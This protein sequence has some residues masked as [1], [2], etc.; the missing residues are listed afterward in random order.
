MNGEE[1]NNIVTNQESVT[2]EVNAAPQVAPQ[3]TEAQVTP[4][5]NVEQPTEAQAV[6]VENVEQPTEVAAPQP[7]EI[8]QE[9]GEAAAVAPA[10]EVATEPVTEPPK[11]ENSTQPHNPKVNDQ[12]IS[13]LPKEKDGSIIG[14]VLFIGLIALFVFFLPNINKFL[15][16]FFPSL[17]P[18][19]QIVAPAPAE[20]EEEEPEKKDDIVYYEIDGTISNA[21][22]DELSLGNFVK[23]NNDGVEKIKF[24]LL[25]NGESVFT[26]NDR[27]KFFLDFYENNSY[28]SSVLVYSFEPIASKETKDFTINISKNLYN[29]AN[30]FTITR[31][32]TSDYP[33]V[34]LNKVE[35]DYKILTCTFGKDEVNYYFIDNY[36][37]SIVESY[38]E[39]NEVETYA[40]DL[41]QYNSLKSK[42][43]G[44]N[45]ISYD[46]IEADNSFEAR[47]TIKLKDISDVD[48]T[49]LATYKYF[50][51]HKESDVVA[52]EM[53]SLGY[54]CS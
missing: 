12:V 13:E 50:P 39:S 8:P 32:K 29:K 1:N 24:F 18:E 52:Y 48:L 11:P 17:D 20:P 41:L 2:P 34:T 26:F 49:K 35:G 16:K 40:D 45:A 3:P 21:K 44:I 47:T 4:V 19:S 25:N 38:K 22:I 42:Y 51:Y 30:K 7:A 37:E 15:A 33:Q 54:T 36:L 43:Q 5:E 6:P 27:T 10:Q 9:G 53:S 31:K 23:D 46:V 28:I 14:I